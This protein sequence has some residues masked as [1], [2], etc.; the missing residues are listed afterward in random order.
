[1]E[2]KRLKRGLRSEC[3]RTTEIKGASISIARR[4]SA[5]MVKGRGLEAVQGL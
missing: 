2:T 3:V 5:G 1:L 4:E